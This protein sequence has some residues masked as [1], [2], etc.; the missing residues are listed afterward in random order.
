MNPQYLIFVRNIDIGV[1]STLTSILCKDSKTFS[2]LGTTLFAL[3]TIS[4]HQLELFDDI[5]QFGVTLYDSICKWI[6]KPNNNLYIESYGRDK[7]IISASQ[8]IATIFFKKSNLYLSF[9]LLSIQY[10]F[11]ISSLFC[12]LSNSFFPPNNSLNLKCCSPSYSINI[13]KFGR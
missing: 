3:P 4:P 6:D 2:A 13:F 9:I 11:F 1:I 8:N 12:V 10:L 5:D 7:H